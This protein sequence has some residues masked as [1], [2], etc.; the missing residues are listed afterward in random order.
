MITILIADDEHAITNY[1]SDLFQSQNLDLDIYTAYSGIEA[2][3]YIE[4]KIFDIVLLDINMP[5]ASGLEVAEKLHRIYPRTRI[6]FLTAYDNFN[7]IYSAM[8]FNCCGYL[9]KIEPERVILS[10]FREIIDEIHAEQQNTQQK[11]ADLQRSLTLSFL[12]QQNLLNAICSEQNIERIKKELQMLPEQ[13]QLDLNNIFYLMYT[14]NLTSSEDNDRIIEN[15]IL[16]R[17][18]LMQLLLAG[19]FKCH[20]MQCPDH[21]LL[22][23]FQPAHSESSV[24]DFNFLSHVADEFSNTLDTPKDQYP[25]IAFLCRE[26]VTLSQIPQVFHW[27]KNYSS[28]S[29]PDHN[30]HVAFVSLRFLKQAS[31]DY[32][33]DET[34]DTLLDQ[35][36]TALYSD[37]TSQ[38]FSIWDRL[39]NNCKHTDVHDQ[40][41][42]TK[43]YY[44][45]M[46]ILI[47]YINNNKIQEPLSKQISITPLQHFEFTDWKSAFHYL[48]ELSMAIFQLNIHRK[49]AKNQQ[50][51]QTI[52]SYIHSNYPDKISLSA[53]AALVN[54]NES[55]ISRIFKSEV[56]EN[57]SEYINHVRLEKAKELLL[58]TNDS[59]QDISE[60]VGYDTPQYFSSIF[61]RLEGL[62]PSEYRLSG[63]LNK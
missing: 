41:K 61:K 62:S 4:K 57:L 13:E 35:L 26:P 39:K 14:R 27:L 60:A 5:G 33:Q 49:S 40:F 38:F 18:Q 8:S 17:M 45:I 6:L 21:S 36:N 42:L 19:K 58:S 12:S 50:I 44:S 10:K 53:V 16:P 32:H 29:L 20:I 56:G 34:T 22:Y 15:F 37:N 23:F 24:S 47:E 31:T 54:Y 9:L 25:D 11:N 63:F 2:L 43:I 1:L 59:I 7:Y 28:Q 48:E 52:K 30:A 3:E 51:V 55:Y 46:L